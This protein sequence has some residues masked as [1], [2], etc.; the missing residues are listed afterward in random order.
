MLLY[1]LRKMKLRYSF[2]D[3]HGND[4]TGVAFHK[5]KPNIAI[6]CGQDYLLNL[7]DLNGD[8]EDDYIESSFTSNQPLISCGFVGDTSMGYATSTV[9]SLEI[10]DFEEM[11]SVKEFT[12]FDH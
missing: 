2:Q 9:N 6:S 4:V 5:T 11:V 8:K 12:K 1:D 7:Y 10:I 3:A